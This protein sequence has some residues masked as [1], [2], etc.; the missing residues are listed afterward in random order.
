MRA[1]VFDLDGTLLQY[2]REYGDLLRTTF[3]EVSGDVDTA[4]LET[5][6]EAFFE[7]F[8]ACNPGPVQRAFEETG[9][10]GDAGRFAERL[11]EA[12]VHATELP[13]SALEDLERLSEQFPLAILTNGLPDWQRGK[14]DAHGIGQ[15]A[16]A[17]VTS[18]EVGEHKPGAAPYR[19]VEQRLDA[20]RFGMIGDSDDDIEGAQAA[21]WDSL[22]YGGGRLRDVPA[23]LSRE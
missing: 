11:H 2:T 22:R 17:V 7:E 13:D 3:Q 15:Y 6:N 5:Y 23:E 4:W 1:L 20:D 19:E 12:E 10:P 14:I 21:G 8:G 18:Y 16:D 9:A